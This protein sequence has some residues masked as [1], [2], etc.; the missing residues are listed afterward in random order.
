VP[1]TVGRY[2]LIARIGRGGMADVMLARDG[3]KLVVLKILFDALAADPKL[4][5]MMRAEAQIAAAIEH[6]NVVDVF[7]LGA[8]DGQHFVAMEYLEGESLLSVLD[9]GI[10]GKRLD[11]LSMTRIVADATK[12]LA[13][14]HA[15]GV[16]HHDISLGNIFVLVSGVV[17][18]LDFGVAKVAERASKTEIKDEKFFGKLAYA[19]PEKLD[20]KQGDMRSDIWSLGCVLWEAATN[21][22]LFKGASDIEIVREVRYVNVPPPSKLVAEVPAALDAIVLKCLQRDP[23]RRYQTASELAT[24]LE[25]VLAAQG[26]PAKNYK[27][28]TYMMQAF[29]DVIAARERLLRDSAGANRPSADVIDAAF[30]GEASRES[31]PVLDAPDLMSTN[32]EVMEIAGAPAPV[33]A[34]VAVP[35]NE[36]DTED[37]NPFADSEEAVETVFDVVPANA[38]A[39]RALRYKA[40][41]SWIATKHGPKIQELQ[42]RT[43]Q[44]RD[45]PEGRGKKLVPFAVGGAV[46]LAI[47]MIVSIKSCVGEPKLPP[48]AP[49]AVSVD[50]APPVDA[51]IVALAPVAIDAAM[52]VKST[53]PEEIEMPVDEPTPVEPR[54]VDK[55]KPRPAKPSRSAQQYYAEG[56]AAWKKNDRRTAYT[57]FT[58][59]RRASATYANNWY[60]LG[61]VHEKAGRKKDARTAYERYLKLAPNAPNNGKLR[62][63]IKKNLL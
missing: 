31:L 19:A 6:P 47:V 44:M 60:G 62:D 14:A 43:Q 29:A 59:G 57:L 24:A 27:I 10:T 46:V 50:A 21:K 61:L 63:H 7:E 52:P 30:G 51:E 42:N 45:R 17:K 36:P 5:E 18:L 53:E 16:V 41:P 25:D 3:A 1:E 11:V 32:G 40:D 58:E 34:A 12:G 13:A 56:L 2:A 22:R 9:K 8:A 38:E 20:G 35:I 55:P 49:L 37:E 23:A 28:A 26:Y 48:P 39:S 54:P 4:V 15:Q 33:S